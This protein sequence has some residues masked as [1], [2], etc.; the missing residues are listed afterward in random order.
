MKPEAVKVP[1]MQSLLVLGRCVRVRW[2]SEV[3]TG[4][5]FETPKL[6]ILGY[7]K[8]SQTCPQASCRLGNVT[9]S[10][11]KVLGHARLAQVSSS[12]GIRFTMSCSCKV[13]ACRAPGCESKCRRCG[14]ACDGVD[15][16]VAKSRKRGSQAGKR[17]AVL[18]A[19]KETRKAANLAQAR[20]AESL[21]GEAPSTA[22]LA[23]GPVETVSD[24]WNAFGYSSA[25][26]KKL[27]SFKA[28]SSPRVDDVR[29]GWPTLVQSVLTAATRVSEILHPGNPQ[30]LLEAVARKILGKEPSDK[31]LQ[32]VASTMGDMIRKA[33][34]GSTEMR[35]LR[36]AAVKGF[37]KASLDK[38]HGTQELPIGKRSRIT[39][40]HDFKNFMEG[41]AV[42]RK[43]FKSARFNEDCLR[44]AVEFILSPQMVGT[45]SWGVREV[46]LDASEK[47]TLPRLVRRRDIKDMH[48]SY[49]AT[50]QPESDRVGRSTF[51]KLVNHITQSGEKLLAAVDYVTGVLIN[52][53]VAL[54]QDVIDVFATGERNEELSGLLEVTRSFLKVQY[55]DHALRIG[56]RVPTHGISY[57]LA[58]QEGEA[59]EPIRSETCGACNI[60]PYLFKQLRDLVAASEDGDVPKAAAVINDA[61]Q[62]LVDVEEKF[63]LY[64]GHRVRV[65]NQQGAINALFKELERE[66][67][68]KGDS[69]RAVITI[70]WKMK[71]EA[72]SARETTQGFYSKRGMSFHGCLISYFRRQEVVKTDEAGN[73]VKSFV[74]ERVNVYLDQ[75]MD[76][77]N[78]QDA[79]AVASMIEACLHWVNKHLPHIKT[80]AIQSDNAKCYNCNFQRMFL[81]LLLCNSKCP[82]K[83]T[84]YIQTETQDG[85]GLIDAHFARAMAHVLRFMR[86]SQRNRIRAIATPRG[87]AAA[88][89]WGG[90]IQNTGVQLVRLNREKLDLIDRILRKARRGIKKY[91]SRC[92]EV[93]FHGPAPGL[94]DILTEADLH[95]AA[96][97]GRVFK[98]TAFAYSGV[99]GATVEVSLGVDKAVTPGQSSSRAARVKMT[100]SMDGAAIKGN[101]PAEGGSTNSNAS[102]DGSDADTGSDDEDEGLSDIDIGDPCNF[103]LACSS[104]SSSSSS[105]AACGS[106]DFF[107]DGE[108]DLNA[109]GAVVV[110]IRG[111]ARKNRAAEDSVEDDEE[112]E[113]EVEADDVLDSDDENMVFAPSEAYIY[114]AA[115]LDPLVML[116]GVHV[117]KQS[118]L[119]NIRGVH[120]SSKR[121]SKS[122]QDGPRR[123][124]I[125]AAGV[126]MASHLIESDGSRVRDGRGHFHEF[127]LAKTVPTIPRKQGWAR[128]Q[129]HG[130][131]YG[132]KYVDRYE[133]DVIELF[134]R[135][136]SVSSEKMG[137]SI[138]REALKRRYPGRLSI[139]TESELRT[140]ISQLFSKSKTTRDGLVQEATT[141]TKKKRGRKSKLS[142]EQEDF[143]EGLIASDPCVKAKKGWQTFLAKF[144]AAAELEKPVKNKINTLKQAKRRKK[145]E[146]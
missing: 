12:I 127:D 41:L 82:V 24:I 23:T 84:Q 45:L 125:V 106:Q 104:S 27:P 130:E 120:H 93:L 78:R 144:P 61:E 79:A 118:N 81:C 111:K 9:E 119:V 2:W 76:G 11:R 56:D 95:D 57:G 68:E 123:A 5:H 52:D 92:N 142:K 99:D 51:Y 69:S 105:T 63:V 21:A 91:F 80:V 43:A 122:H 101:K 110:D 121:K 33:S 109:M 107:F 114:D 48:Q 28:R 26:R 102:D 38:F 25:Q 18:P 36:A 73:E 87:L 103:S 59:K 67:L 29:A 17:K 39:G 124:D 108:K 32:N 135:G 64:M 113:D 55:D 14:C 71:F 141:G 145:T 66:C 126:R 62:V 31:E 98:F 83:V 138:M 37:S 86:A 77:D 19:V 10:P 89:A 54:L 136:A 96:R 88:L 30:A 116:T 6:A 35:I 34:P 115:S 15:P 60:V 94:P 47:V 53:S 137:P 140:K 131:Q 90:G 1:K 139:P 72:M 20:I 85:K 8:P 4:G 3:G 100:G 97:S 13:G 7:F 42:G 46:H 112:T 133:K 143:L 58:K 132:V 129:V 70:D 74:A 75:I 146:L 65:A 128:R 134:N 44:R 50:V 40:Y 117:I 22:E 49:L 16:A